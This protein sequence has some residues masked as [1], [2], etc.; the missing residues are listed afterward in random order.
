[1]VLVRI[2]HHAFERIYPAKS[3]DDFFAS[4]LLK[5]LRNLVAD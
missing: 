4:Q 3:D 1:M 5:A 2:V